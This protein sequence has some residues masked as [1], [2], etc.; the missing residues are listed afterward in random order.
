MKQAVDKLI[1]CGS[2]GCSELSGLLPWVIRVIPDIYGEVKDLECKPAYGEHSRFGVFFY[3]LADGDQL[4]RFPET[5]PRIILRTSDLLD[6]TGISVELKSQGVLV[7]PSKEY[8]REITLATPKNGSTAADL[9]F[10]D[11]VGIDQSIQ[12]R[13]ITLDVAGVFQDRLPILSIPER[14]LISMDLIKK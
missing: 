12:K 9:C 4:Q 5:K 6:N 8:S 3:A 10:G 1:Q 7:F 11:Q 13:H 14:I 2:I